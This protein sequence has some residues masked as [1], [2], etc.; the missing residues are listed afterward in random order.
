MDI[1]KV[2]KDSDFYNYQSMVNPKAANV[3]SHKV[4]DDYIDKKG[5]DYRYQIAEHPIA[6]LR[7]RHKD[8]TSGVRC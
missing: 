1:D 5:I 7:N 3:A 6:E 4:I 8:N 2:S